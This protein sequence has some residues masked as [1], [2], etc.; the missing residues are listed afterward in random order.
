MVQFS[1]L[2]FAKEAMRQGSHWLN[3]F[4]ISSAPFIFI[5]YLR[6]YRGVKPIKW[7]LAPIVCLI[8]VKK[9]KQSRQRHSHNRIDIEPTQLG[10]NLCN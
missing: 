4:A 9:S 1:V 6:H 3:S 5:V 7:N 10:Q 2:V 8:F